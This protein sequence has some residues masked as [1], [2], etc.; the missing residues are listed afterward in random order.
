MNPISQTHP[1]ISVVTSHFTRTLETKGDEKIIDILNRY[2]IP[3]SSISMYVISESGGDPK[4]AACLDSKLSQFENIS[5]ILLYFNRNVNPF[6]FSLDEFETISSKSVGEQATEYFYQQLD[7]DSSSSVNYLKKLDTE[8]CRYVIAE[9]V[10]DTVLE[11]IPPG[12]HLVV[13]VSGGG[14]SNSLLHGLTQIKDYGLVV[15][16]VI[17]TGIPEW[18]L[19]VPRAKELC[20]KYSLDLTVV[21]EQ[22]VKSLL[23][24][25]NDNVSLMERFLKVFKGDDFEFIGTLLI[26]LALIRHAK[27]IGTSYISTGLNLEDVLCENLFRVSS[28]M[29]PAACPKRIIGNINLVYPLWLCPKRIIDG[30]FPKFSLENYDVRYPCHSLGRNLYYSL[31]YTIQSQF[32]GFVEQLA[33]G[34]S[35]LSLQDAPNYIYDQQLGFHVERP[36]PTELRQ[37]FQNLI[38]A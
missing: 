20:D 32:P 29:K 11:N 25:S 23:G 16:P 13:G 26:R 28:G 36:I 17:I 15:H 18:D 7:N 10:K 37:K 19:G 31:I 22:D 8:E 30:C 33:R 14:D 35:E 9:R 1:K 3:W 21:D 4:L 27:L 24:I 34:F 12:T 2:Q 5:E 6:K 38:N